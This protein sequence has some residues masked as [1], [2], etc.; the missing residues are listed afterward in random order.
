M[1]V[2]AHRVSA[3]Q[4]VCAV[5]HVLL[6]PRPGKAWAAQAVKTVHR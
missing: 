2:F 5:V 4:A 3:A 1:A 6:T